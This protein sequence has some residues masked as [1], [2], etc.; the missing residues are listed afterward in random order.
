LKQGSSIPNKQSA[1]S[2]ASSLA[3]Q[4]H[5]FPLIV[6]ILDIGDAAENKRVLLEQSERDPH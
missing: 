6:H 5:V 4:S 3:T 1:P 2:F